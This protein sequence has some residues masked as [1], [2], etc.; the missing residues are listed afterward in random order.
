MTKEHRRHKG[1]GPNVAIRKIAAKNLA[2]E[3]WVAKLDAVK[4]NREISRLRQIG[5]WSLSSFK[6]FNFTKSRPSPEPS[7]SPPFEPLIFFPMHPNPKSKFLAIIQDH[8]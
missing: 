8:D 6:N 1:T 2:K 3:L 4:N 7:F 5:L